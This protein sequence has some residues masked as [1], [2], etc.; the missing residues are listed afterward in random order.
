VRLRALLSGAPTVT[1]AVVTTS[2]SVARTDARA[3][4]TTYS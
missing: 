4:T 2:I 3:A 1:V